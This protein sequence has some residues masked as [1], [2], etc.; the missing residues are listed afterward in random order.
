MEFYFQ[1]I[2]DTGSKKTI[3]D[4]DKPNRHITDTIKIYL[5]VDTYIIVSTYL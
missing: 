1:E 4:I 5:F 2:K 3:D